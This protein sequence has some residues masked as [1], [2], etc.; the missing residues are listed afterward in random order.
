MLTANK[1][2]TTHPIR[3]DYFGGIGKHGN[4]QGVTWYLDGN[5]SKSVFTHQ[6]D[7]TLK[8]VRTCTKFVSKF[9][10]TSSRVKVNVVSCEEVLISGVYEIIVVLAIS[11]RVRINTVRG[12]QVNVVRK[13]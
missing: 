7:F 4:A 10:A 6:K 8:P 2:C 9:L 3:V 13:S 12:S 5:S 11:G 1:E